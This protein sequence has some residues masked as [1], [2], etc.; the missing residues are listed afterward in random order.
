MWVGQTLA[1][2]FSVCIPFEAV[3]SRP[4]QLCEKFGR[5]VVEADVGGPVWFG[6]TPSPNAV[7]YMIVGPDGVKPSVL[8]LIKRGILRDD[9]PP[10][11][12]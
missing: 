4:E 1:Y 6:Q 11:G 8:E 7:E 3:D 2:D 9:G 12:R 5:S 10:L